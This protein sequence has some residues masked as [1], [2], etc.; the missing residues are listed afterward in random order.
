MNNKFKAALISLPLVFS[1]TGC[2]IVATDDAHDWD[3][4][5]SIGETWKE[6][7]RVNN[8]KI[9]GLKV[10][11]DFDSVRTLMG[12]PRFNE[13]FSEGA[14]N[15]QVLFYRTRRVKG[16]NVTTKDECTPL[17]FK[18]GTLIGFGHKAYNKL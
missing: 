7:Q 10:G 6:E 5:N 1:M 16:D 9:A 13:A 11:A 12:T 17:I 14:D 4:N 15:Y 2:V 8:E 3:S 18:N